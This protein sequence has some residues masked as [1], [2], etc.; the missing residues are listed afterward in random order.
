MDVA[1]CRIS[2]DLAI[3]VAARRFARKS[4]PGLAESRSAAHGTVCAEQVA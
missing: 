1:T 2:P 3:G 4:R